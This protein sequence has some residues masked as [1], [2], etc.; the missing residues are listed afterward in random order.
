MYRLGL[1]GFQNSGKGYLNLI[2]QDNG[3]DGQR[4][5]YDQANF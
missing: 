5:L 1:G 4:T 3:A 2:Q